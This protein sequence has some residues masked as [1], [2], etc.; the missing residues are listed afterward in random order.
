[1]SSNSHVAPEL[2]VSHGVVR[3]VGMLPGPVAGRLFAFGDGAVGGDVGI[4]QLDVALV[5]LGLG[6]DDLKNPFRAGQSRQQGVELLGNLGN[7]LG[8]GPGVLEE[9][10]D[11]AD[12]HHAR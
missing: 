5:L 2:G 9:G 12:V 6:I 8:E 4:D 1:M 11:G 10:G 3:G 7:G